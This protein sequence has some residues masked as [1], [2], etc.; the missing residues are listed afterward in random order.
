MTMVMAAAMTLNRV[1]TD[2]NQ[3]NQMRTSNSINKVLEAK[4]MI[5]RQ[6]RRFSMSLVL[7]FRRRKAKRRIRNMVSK[8]AR[9]L[10]I[11]IANG[12]SSSSMRYSSKRD[13][14]IIS[15]VVAVGLC[16]LLHD[17]GINVC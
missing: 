3:S 8:M 12:V 9:E 2:W 6:D 10:T 4:L 15:Q 17:S 5:C 13:A 1:M 7:R 16:F 14:Y 11:L